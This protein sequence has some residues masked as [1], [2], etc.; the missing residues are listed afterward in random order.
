MKRM[1]RIALVIILLLLS[2]YLSHSSQE[3]QPGDVTDSLPSPENISLFLLSLPH[4]L[5][6][7]SFPQVNLT[8]ELVLKTGNIDFV[9][10][11]KTAWLKDALLE[12][13]EVEGIH[14]DD[15]SREQLFS[16]IDTLP[17]ELREALALLIYTFNDVTILCRDATQ[18]LKEDDITFL[19]GHNEPVS[20]LTDILRD[21][22]MEKIGSLF[23]PNLNLFS[24]DTSNELTPI[25]EKI[26]MKKMVEGS[27]S[28]FD[29]LQ[30]AVPVLKKYD[31]I[32]SE[33]LLEDPA[34]LIYIGGTMPAS[35]NG[36][37][38]LIVDL[39]G[40]D[41]YYAQ[42][43]EQ[44]VSL[45]ID[46]NGDDQYIGKKAHAFL[47]VD[48]LYDEEGNDVYTAS[49][50]SLA[51]ARAGISLL[52]DNSGDDIYN[53]KFYSQGSAY[54]KGI[55]A[56]VD[57]GGNDMYTASNFSQAYANGF[58]CAC[59]LDTAGNDFY[60]SHSHS[61]GSSTGGGISFLLDFLGNDKYVSK[62]NSQGSGEGL[63]ENKMSIGSLIDLAGNDNYVSRKEAQ[64]FGRNLGIG[65]LLDFLGDDEY[66]S[67]N[68]S[69]AC[70]EL[71]GVA[72]LIDLT[73]KNVWDSV[74]SSQEYQKVGGIAILLK[75]MD[76]LSNEKLW[77]LV[78]YM[79]GNN[80]LPLSF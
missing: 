63:M 49:N 8:M 74:S 24:D 16:E 71:G 68:D 36:N 50:F 53:S 27:I 20:T 1:K 76:D 18:S 9:Y 26:D 54:A 13:Y 78:E 7:R 39:G 41:I 55:G 35:Y 3:I 37:Y 42:P 77:W 28:L 52:M 15:A 64:G 66:C 10:G 45:L 47:G 38:S 2:P 30:K 69:Q 59:L 44:A 75:G 65:A 61:Q 73:G 46:M 56:L 11:K 5:E 17:Y 33:K 6:R 57:I 4:K 19:E 32:P 40:D 25:V 29:A 58:G 67:L 48:M 70:G 51:Y 23:L 21:V 72:C 43:R 62:Q 79:K 12:F 22:I 14:I 31:N 34:G 80:I 60:T